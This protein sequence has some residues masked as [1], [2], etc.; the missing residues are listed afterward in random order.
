MA[1]SCDGVGV[2]SRHK[3][4]VGL[5]NAGRKSPS[6]VPGKH[7]FPD[8]LEFGVAYA[9]LEC[10]DLLARGAPGVHSAR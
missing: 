5:K 9:M 1:D 3:R 4:P 6:A 8:V 10:S 7:Q 2:A